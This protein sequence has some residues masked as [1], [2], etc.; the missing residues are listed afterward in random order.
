[1]RMQHRIIYQPSCRI[2]LV[3]V[4]T[5]R[6]GKGGREE[7]EDKKMQKQETKSNIKLQ[8]S[9]FRYHRNCFRD[10][11]NKMGINA[12]KST[13]NQTGSDKAPFNFILRIIL[14]KKSRIWNTNE[15]LDA[16]RN[17]GCTE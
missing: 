2:S 10:F 14:N 11:R 13:Y 3:K 12:A 8:L 7:K 6:E 16:F 1:M 9:N 4:R 15:L 5:M 17:M